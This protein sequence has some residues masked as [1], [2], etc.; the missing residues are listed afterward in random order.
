M[1]HHGGRTFRR[2]ERLSTLACLFG[3]RLRNSGFEVLFE[4]PDE[5]LPS[6]VIDPNAIGRAVGNLIDNAVKYSDGDRTIIVRL[7]VEDAGVAVSVTD[8][9]IGIPADEQERIFERFHRVSTG[10][11]HDVKGSGLGLSLVQHIVKAHG[12]RVSVESSPGEGST[13]TIH[14]P[15]RSADLGEEG[16]AS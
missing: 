16:E 8:H 7:A 1:A 14:L 15:L 4:G 10:L 2:T 13:F 12:G 5:E 9:G 3:V 6:V 11:V